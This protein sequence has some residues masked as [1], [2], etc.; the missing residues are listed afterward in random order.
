[1]LILCYCVICW[2]GGLL[3]EHPV[4][5]AVKLIGPNSTLENCVIRLK[6]AKYAVNITGNNCKIINGCF[7]IEELS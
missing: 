2:L 7:K 5:S 1:M 3:L 4:I 6:S